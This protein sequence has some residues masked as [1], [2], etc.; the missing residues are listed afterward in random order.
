MGKTD[1]RIHL[2]LDLKAEAE[3]LEQEQAAV[4]RNEPQAAMEMGIMWAKKMV[5]LELMLMVLGLER[6]ANTFSIINNN[7]LLFHHHL[8]WL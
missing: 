2:V 6:K 3:V 4:R 7:F 1:V 8:S 5:E